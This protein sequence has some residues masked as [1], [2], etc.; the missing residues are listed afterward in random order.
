[1]LFELTICFVQH[2]WHC[3]HQKTTHEFAPLCP[4][5]VAVAVSRNSNGV[6]GAA[7]D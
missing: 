5:R 6:F 1:M 4:T 2:P 7:A 3:D